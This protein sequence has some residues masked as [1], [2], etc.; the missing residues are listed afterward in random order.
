MET[1]EYIWAIKIEKKDI[2]TY[3][4]ETPVCPHCGFTSVDL[5]GF[6]DETSGDDQCTECGKWYSWESERTIEFFTWEIDWLEKWK[7][8][9]RDKINS[10]RLKERGL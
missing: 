9:N 8:Y 3:Q 2:D 7:K 5:E 10:A 4:T 1:R 6:L